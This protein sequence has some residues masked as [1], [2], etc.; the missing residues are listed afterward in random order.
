VVM[1]SSKSFSL[2]GIGLAGSERLRGSRQGHLKLPAEAKRRQ[3]RSA[4]PT[5]RLQG[6]E[7]LYASQL[8]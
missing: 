8:S 5:G 1:V 7:Q 6:T 2:I 4:A 3:A